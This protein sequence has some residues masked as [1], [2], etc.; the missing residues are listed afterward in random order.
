SL[1]ARRIDVILVPI[2][3]PG[4]RW[5]QMNNDRRDGRLW[6]EPKYLDQSRRFW[7]DL[8]AAVKGHPAVCALNVLNEPHPRPEGGDLNAFNRAMLEAIR[9][10]DERVPVVLECAQFADPQ[11]ITPLAPVADANVLYSVHMYEPYEY[12]AWRKH[13]GKLKYPGPI[14][15]AE[16]GPVE[17][18]SVHWLDRYFEPLR[19]WTRRHGMGPDRVL[20]GEFGCDRRNAGA[21]QYLADLIR[22]FDRERWH[23]LFYA[24]REDTWDAMNYEAGNGAAWRVFERRL[25]TP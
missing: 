25:A 7:Q 15:A 2:T 10:N 8:A 13:R 23:W 20:V 5:R 11:A 16:G 4:A 12:T 1:A 18:V 19:E 14:P 17:E 21:P 9:S 3:L 24:F 22:I 6:R